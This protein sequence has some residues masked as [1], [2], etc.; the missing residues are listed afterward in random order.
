MFM[1]G[2]TAKAKAKHFVLLVAV[3]SKLKIKKGMAEAIPFPISWDHP[4]L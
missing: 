1:E 3:A 4:N 2:V